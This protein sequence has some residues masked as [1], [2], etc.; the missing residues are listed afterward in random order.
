M[1]KI[2]LD[3]AQERFMRSNSTVV[4]A[5]NGKYF[6]YIPFWFEQAPFP[7]RRKDEGLTLFNI[8]PLESLPNVL[9][10]KVSEL[11]GEKM[12]PEDFNDVIHLRTVH[13]F[14][15]WQRVRILFGKPL[16][17]FAEIEVGHPDAKIIGEVKEMGRVFPL[18]QFF[19]KKYK[20]EGILVEN[21]KPK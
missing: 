1:K 20:G 6:H 14:T 15:F 4:D 9:K 7:F 16:H 5:G 2:Y 21:E 18:F 10:E 19:R 8:H 17:T 12:K 13:R 11:R 3:E